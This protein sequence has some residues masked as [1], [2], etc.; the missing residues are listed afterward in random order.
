MKLARILAPLVVLG[1]SL[2]LSATVASASGSPGLQCAVG[3]SPLV[4]HSSDTM[5]AKLVCHGWTAGAPGAVTVGLVGYTVTAGGT[6]YPSCAVQ[7][8]GPPG[9]CNEGALYFT[10]PDNGGSAT[11][12]VSGGVLTMTTSGTADYDASPDGVVSG[13]DVWNVTNAQPDPSAWV[14]SDPSWNPMA[15]TAPSGADAAFVGTA[16]PA[17]WSGFSGA[18]APASGADYTGS[19]GIRTQLIAWV[20][21]HGAGMVAGLI[22]IGLVFALLVRY[23]RRATG[24]A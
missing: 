5:T 1:C 17:S 4:L 8:G 13:S 18:T 23:A 16:D 22:A 11:S 3:V 19:D 10:T 2:G 14:F 6:T 12:V 21:D 9:N 15:V 20:G 24:A 7:H